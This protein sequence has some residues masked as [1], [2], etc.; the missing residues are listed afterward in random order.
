M[1]ENEANFTVQGIKA[2]ADAR[3]IKDELEHLDGVMGA[4]VDP[5]SGAAEVRYDVD[6]LAEERVRRTVRD[7]GFEVE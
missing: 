4:E 1:A 6:I 5:E 3:G 7:M 2:E